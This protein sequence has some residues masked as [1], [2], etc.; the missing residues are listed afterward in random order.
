MSS[1]G[2]GNVDYTFPPRLMER[3][4]TEMAALR[5][6]VSE[7]R[8]GQTQWETILKMELGGSFAHF[9]T[10]L[11]SSLDRIEGRIDDFELKLPAST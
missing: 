10:R 2:T 5:R 4:L 6:E 1:T 9:E 3:V 7:I 8:E 11:G